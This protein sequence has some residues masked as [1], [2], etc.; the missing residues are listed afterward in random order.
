MIRYSKKNKLYKNLILFAILLLLGIIFDIFYGENV[1]N[2]IDLKKKS[3]FS[4]HVLDVGCADAIYINCKDKNILIDSGNIDTNDYVVKYLKNQG[5]SSF[6]MVVATHPHVDHIGGMAKIID[7]FEIDNFFMSKLN[8]EIEPTTLSYKNMLNKL[9]DEDVNVKVPVLGE[10]ISIGDMKIDIL[11]PKE[12]QSYKEVNNHSIILKVT[13]GK[14]KFLFM[15][16]AERQAED[17]LIKSGYDLKADVLKVGHH[18]SMT[19]TTE[20]LLNAVK[21][22]YA[23]ISV[24]PNV[25]ALPNDKILNRISSRNIEMYRTDKNGNVIFNSDGNHISAYMEKDDV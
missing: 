23:V 19:S 7:N 12:L 6:D 25:H 13:Y 2:V 14:N 17:S 16:D 4:V 1:K 18:G 22:D 8:K 9:I 10:N 5:V 21:P 15:G 11:G 3:D 20:S 24:G